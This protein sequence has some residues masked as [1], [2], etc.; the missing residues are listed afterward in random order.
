LQ[1]ESG[2]EESIM[3]HGSWIMD[4][5][6]NPVWLELRTGTGRSYTTL[7]SVSASF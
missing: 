7:L 1:F 6:E 4:I 5:Q 2:F 3:D